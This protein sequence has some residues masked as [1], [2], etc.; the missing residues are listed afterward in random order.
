MSF[1]KHNTVPPDLRDAIE[2]RCEA[3]EQAWMDGG[4]PRIEEYLDGAPHDARPLLAVKLLRI[5]LDWRCRRGEFPDIEEYRTR[6]PTLESALRTWLEQAK[7]GAAQ[8]STPP[9]PSTPDTALHASASNWSQLQGN[10]PALPQFLGEYE[11]LESLGTGGMGEVYRARHRR[12]GKIVALKVLPAGSQGSR[13]RVARFLCEIRAIGDLDHP[14]VVEAHDAGEEGGIVYLAMKLVEGEDLFR[15]VQRVGPLPV[16]EAC[17]LVRQAALGLEYLHQH[18]LVHRDVKPSNIMRAVDGAVKVLDLGLARRGMEVSKDYLTPTGHC[19][20]TPDF[21]AP[22]QAKDAALADA[23]ADVYSL[24]CTL[25]YLLTG[26]SPFAHRTGLY[27]KLEAHQAETPADVRSARPEVPEAL[28][29]FLGRM[30][31]KRPEDRPQTAAEVAMALTGFSDSLTPSEEPLRQAPPLQPRRNSRWRWWLA[32]ALPLAGLLGLAA[33]T[34]SKPRSPEPTERSLHEEEKR[35]VPAKLPK[36][37]TIRLQVTRLSPAEGGNYSAHQI[38]LL[39]G[40]FRAHL[41]DKAEPKAELSEDA[42]AFM[43]AFNPASED[44]AE[45]LEQFIPEGEAGSPPKR[46]R[47][48]NPMRVIPLNDGVGLQAF[49]VVASRQP[50]PPYSEWRKRRSSSPWKQTWAK[51]GVVLRSD[52]KFTHE[53]FG[54]GV[55]RGP[56][57]AA[58]DRIAFEGLVE[59]L[60]GLEKVEAVAVLG[61]AVDP[62]K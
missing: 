55:V 60:K 61:F 62:P 21:L 58:A 19:M 20:G 4:R 48:L 37:L 25:F 12:L 51:T 53:I 2:P 34:L 49:A 13:E 33:W 6:F 36:P 44:K 42:Y 41:N 14:N 27:Q 7:A 29:M 56:E 10:A 11:L 52:G 15:L 1:A 16:V 57:E 40:T 50:L 23:R 17:G 31:A 30:L 46:A 45:K 59:W 38:G 35:G 8:I 47:T 26:R 43:M 5:E 18:G 3:F 28:A 54:E 24:G 39:G 32:A 9:P 22:E